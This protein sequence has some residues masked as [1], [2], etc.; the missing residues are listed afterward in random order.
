M[1]YLTVAGDDEPTEKTN[2]VKR[3]FKYLP[4]AGGSSATPFQGGWDL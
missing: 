4:W 3:L 1:D 2:K